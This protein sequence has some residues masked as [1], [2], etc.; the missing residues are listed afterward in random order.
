MAYGTTQ[1]RGQ[2]IL[3][4][5]FSLLRLPRLLTGR[6]LKSRTSWSSDGT[7]CSFPSTDER[8]VPLMQTR[9][10]TQP[11]R[12][13]AGSFCTSKAGVCSL[14]H[15]SASAVFAWSLAWR[16][17]VTATAAVPCT[18]QVRLQQ[19]L[20]R[21]Q[22]RLSVSH[23]QKQTVRQFHLAV[24]TGVYI[25]SCSWCHLITWACCWI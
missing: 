23:L 21:D 19:Q 17:R 14:Q 12:T 25:L 11:C 4:V 5:S 20:Q 8:G 18:V 15:L 24:S 13:L 10:N 2:K 16:A 9:K 1:H 6:Q 22:L 3:P 7:S